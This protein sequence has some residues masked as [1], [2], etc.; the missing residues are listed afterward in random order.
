MN[1]TVNQEWSLHCGHTGLTQAGLQ[2]FEPNGVRMKRDQ[3]KKG[4][5]WMGPFRCCRSTQGQE[6]AGTHWKQCSVSA[7]LRRDKQQVPGAVCPQRLLRADGVTSCLH[8]SCCPHTDTHWALC[9]V[10]NRSKKAL[11]YQDGLSCACWGCPWQRELCKYCFS[12]CLTHWTCASW[13]LHRD[14]TLWHSPRFLLTACAV[15]STQ[16]HGIPNT[17]TPQR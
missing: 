1:T 17:A 3:A 11:I 12:S 10:R 14:R 7:W 9:S 2:A 15:L 6:A 8:L 4:P 16:T 5:G 13:M